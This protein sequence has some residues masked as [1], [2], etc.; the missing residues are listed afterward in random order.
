MVAI[1]VAAQGTI[2]ALINAY[3]AARNHRDSKDAIA[4]VDAKVVDTHVAIN[5]RMD[6]LLKAAKAQGAQ[7]QRDETRQDAKRDPN[8]RLE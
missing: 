3:I 2:I 7:D 6:Q 4:A 8:D 5:G 1:I